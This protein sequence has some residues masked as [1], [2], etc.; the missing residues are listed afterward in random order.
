LHHYNEVKSSAKANCLELERVN[1]LTVSS[2]RKNKE[3][4]GKE[5]T[6]LN[7]DDIN[8]DDDISLK[9]V[10]LTADHPIKYIAGFVERSVF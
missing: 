10:D 1:I 2:R 5:E 6:P 3:K 9:Y 7:I 8:I 4:D